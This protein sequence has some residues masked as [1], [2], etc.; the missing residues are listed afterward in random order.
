MNKI[1]GL[2]N[3][4]FIL[5]EHDDMLTFQRQDRSKLGECKEQFHELMI[6]YLIGSA[7]IENLNF[8]DMSIT[9]TDYVI[10]FK[11][12]IFIRKTNEINQRTSIAQRSFQFV[13]E[14]LKK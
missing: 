7:P 10:E 2:I 9:I 13:K 1:S 6:D 8:N 12:P 14:L 4:E 11:S 5:M 3:G